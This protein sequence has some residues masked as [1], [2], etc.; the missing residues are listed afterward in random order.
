[1]RLT[2]AFV[3]SL[4]ALVFFTAF[5][6]SFRLCWFAPF[7]A[8]VFQKKSLQTS[9]WIAALSGLILDVF[10]SETRFGFFTLISGFSTICCHRFRRF[11][12]EER[13]LSIP[14]YAGSISIV[15]SLLHLILHPSLL[16]IKTLLGSV[17]LFPILDASYTLVLFTLPV[18]LCRYFFYRMPR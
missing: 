2:L 17:L 18:Y 8:L 9:L 3:L 13:L 5:T 12:F 16:S 1:M 11:F 7:L 10:A 6:P 15:F 4:F 14:L